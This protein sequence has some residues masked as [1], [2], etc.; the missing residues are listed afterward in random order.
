[1]KLIVTI[2]LNVLTLMIVSYLVPGFRFDS[3][4]ATI[5]TAIVIGVTN[6]FIKPI[7]KI[8]FLPL[9]II[10][11]GVS[12]FLIN[13]VLLWAVSFMVPG[14]EIEG[15]LTAVIASIVLSLVSTF[16]H[17]LAEEKG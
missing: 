4:W 11:L 3:L 13:V 16:L 2:S 15:F 5:V 6:T 10:T 9:T 17:K 12:S 1:M 7:L 14:F 8:I